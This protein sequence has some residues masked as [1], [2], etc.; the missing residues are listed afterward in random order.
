ML[1]AKDPE[2]PRSVEFLPL[3]HIMPPV[4][5]RDLYLHTLLVLLQ[6]YVCMESF[7]NGEV[8]QHGRETN[9]LVCSTHSW[10]L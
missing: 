5:S 8:W 6:R 3:V 2:R 7:P 1:H 4:S 10:L 9:G